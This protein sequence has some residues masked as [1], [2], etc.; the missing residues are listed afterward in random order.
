MENLYVIKIGGNI[1]D[2]EKQLKAFLE[3]FA[4]L[5]GE[6]LLVHGGGKAATELSRTL[7]IIPEIIEGRRVTDADTLK[8]VT[9]VYAG[10][11]NKTIVAGLQALHCN[12]IGLTG[13]DG[14]CIPATQREVKEINYGFV[15][16]V[17]AG[18][19][20]TTTLGAFLEKG[21]VPIIAPITHDRKGQ[22]LNTN[23]DTI[24][25]C[26]AAAFAKTHNVKLI[27]CF[28]KAGVLRDVDDEQ[29]VIDR[30]SSFEYEKLKQEGII[31]KGM[32]PKL[33]NAFFALK[34]GVDSVYITHALKVAD[35]MAEKNNSGTLLYQINE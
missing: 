19:L 1:V 10:L 6:K 17:N 32:L 27:Y 33:D 20:N 29:S 4:A 24:A 11:V 2:D 18:E 30:L 22:L 31:S 23:A 14:N 7:G 34:Q 25:A 9:M 16:D 8:I 35:A 5:E 15:G 12:A 13:V 28:E 3:Q 21:L 26:L